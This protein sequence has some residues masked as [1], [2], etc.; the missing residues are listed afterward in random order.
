MA[1]RRVEHD[2]EIDVRDV[3]DRYEDLDADHDGDNSVAGEYESLR[4]LLRE[5]RDRGG[6]VEH[7][8]H[9]YPGTLIQDRGEVSSDYSSVEYDGVT[10]RYRY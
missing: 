4:D 2:D 9:W 10:Y 7:R 3:I 1:A 5:L 6:D 8:G